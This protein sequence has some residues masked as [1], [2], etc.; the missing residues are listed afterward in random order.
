MIN[1][2]SIY[3]QTLSSTSCRDNILRFPMAN[4]DSE[5]QN[6]VETQ[7]QDKDKWYIDTNHL[8]KIIHTTVIR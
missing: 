7:D 2:N 4:Y 8:D 1:K 3:I 5:D 6:S